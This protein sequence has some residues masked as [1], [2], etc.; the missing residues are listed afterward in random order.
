MTSTS[1]RAAARRRDLLALAGIGL[2]LATIL[3]GAQILVA[4]ALTLLP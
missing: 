4:A 1:P 3:L 2:I